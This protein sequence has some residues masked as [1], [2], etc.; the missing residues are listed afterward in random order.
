MLVKFRDGSTDYYDDEPF[1]SGG[2][3]TLHYSKNKQY[4]LK[5]YHSAD[6]ARIDA[7]NKIIGNFN[8]PKQEPSSA[9]W[10]AW[11]NAIAETPKLGVRMANVNVQLEHKQLTWW[12]GARSLKRLGPEI[13]GNWLDRVFVGINMARIAWLLHG[14]GLC[15]SDFSG[16]NFLVNVAQQHAVLIDLDSLVVPGVLPPEML[17]TGDYMAPEIVMGRGNIAGGAKPA[18]ETDLHSLA[19]L[20]YQLLLMRHPLKGPKQHSSDA[21]Q[22][23]LLALGKNALYIEDP[24]DRSNRPADPFRGAWLLG[25][26]MEALLRRAF[27]AGLRSPTQRPLA[28]E[29]SDALI[30]M[31]EQTVPCSNQNCDAKAFVLLRDKEAICPWCETKVS[32]PA[33]VPIVRLYDSAGQRGHFVQGRARVVGWQNRTLN[34]WH[35]QSGLSASKPE[36]RTPVAEFEYKQSKWLLRNIALPDLRVAS[37]DGVRQ[38]AIDEPIPLEDGQR[39]LL[40]NGNSARLAL[41][42]MQKL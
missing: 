31:S 13:R 2:Q 12:I 38:V 19:V 27:T 15:H 9:H 7:L 17:G 24:N 20:I 11:P 29:W 30:R 32:R 3:G 6:R 1:A 4:V 42:A 8:V 10:F 34:R 22:D 28:V 14:N 23:D 5:L 33:H 16:D 39:L 26:E 37:R 36:D 41:V 35:A 25:E 18:I 21:E 40:G